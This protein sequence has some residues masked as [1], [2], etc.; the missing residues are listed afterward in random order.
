MTYRDWE[1]EQQPVEI[2]PDNELAY[3]LWC[4]VGNQWRLGMNGPVA[5]DYLPLQ[6]ELGRMGLSDADYDSLFADIRVM[7]AEALDA[8]RSD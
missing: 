3:S 1:A 4:K 6:H 5:L 8:I 2:W 7:E